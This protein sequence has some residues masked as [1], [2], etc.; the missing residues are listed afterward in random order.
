LQRGRV[1]GGDQA[2]IGALAPERPLAKARQAAPGALGTPGQPAIEQRAHARAYD[3]P[4][5]TTS[6]K[7]TTEQIF[8]A[9]PYLG[10]AS[11]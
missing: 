6:T 3:W 7:S 5:P 9:T 11:V 10:R 1:A 4:L 2:G 8:R